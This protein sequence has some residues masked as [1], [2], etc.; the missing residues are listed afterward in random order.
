MEGGVHGRDQ[1][2]KVIPPHQSS[3][4]TW[5]RR[6]DT[7]YAAGMGSGSVA[8]LLHLMPDP[9]QKRALPRAVDFADLSAFIGNDKDRSIALFRGYLALAARDLLYRQSEL[10]ALQ[11]TLARFD[12]DD[13]SDCARGR[14][15]TGDA[16]KD[17]QLL[18]REPSTPH[19]ADPGPAEAVPSAC[20]AV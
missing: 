6:K 8:I 1:C 12:R 14:Y 10:E 9:E 20:T 7:D 17:W 16:A 11:A 15:E 4:G 13:A 3:K 18:T 5:Q 19:S 2:C